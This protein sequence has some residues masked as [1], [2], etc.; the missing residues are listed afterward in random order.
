M[1]KLALLGL[2]VALAAGNVQAQEEAGLLTTQTV[3]IG[4]VVAGGVVA[5]VANSNGNSAPDGGNGGGETVFKCAG[6]DP[7]VSGLCVGSKEQVFTTGTGTNTYTTTGIVT[8][9]YLPTAQ[10]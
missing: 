4:G 6:T 3:I 1:K 8:F 2:A 7:L 10:K 9:T 5:T